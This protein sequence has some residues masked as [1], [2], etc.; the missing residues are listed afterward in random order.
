MVWVIDNL[1]TLVREFTAVATS[2]PISAVL[3]TLGALI[4]A[5]A[6]LYFGYLTVR[7]L[8]EFVLPEV[9]G[10]GSGPSQSGH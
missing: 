10:G 4:T 8:L 5:F 7:G 6:S 1:V 9:S 2:D 3:L